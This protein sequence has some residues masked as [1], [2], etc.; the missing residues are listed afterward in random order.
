MERQCIPWIEFLPPAE[1]ERLFPEGR[2]SEDQFAA[3]Q[4]WR[5]RVLGMPATCDD[6]ETLLKIARVCQRT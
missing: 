2:L 6:P 4:E 3:R 1:Y 5:R